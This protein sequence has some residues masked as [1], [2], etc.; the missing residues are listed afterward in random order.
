MTVKYRLGITNQNAD[1]LSRQAWHDI[2]ENM[3]KF[4]GREWNDQEDNSLKKGEMSGKA[5]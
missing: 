1:G 4:E 5:P 3:D 2:E